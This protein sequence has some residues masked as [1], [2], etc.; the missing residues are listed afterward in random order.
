MSN[1]ITFNRKC[2]TANVKCEEFLHLYEYEYE[3]Q[4]LISDKMTLYI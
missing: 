3:L 2:I 4:Y 1:E